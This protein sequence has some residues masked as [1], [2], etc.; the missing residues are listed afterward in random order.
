MK[1]LKFRFILSLS[2]FIVASLSLVAVI[3][4]IGVYN[5]GK[6]FAQQRGIPVVNYVD[7]IIDGDEF[8][9]FVS[10]PTEVDPYYDDT[11]LTLLYLNRSV[12]ASYLYTMTKGINEEGEE[13]YFYIIDGSCPREEDGFSPLMEEEDISDWGPAIL[14]TFEDGEIHCSNPINQKNWGWVVSTYKGIKDSSGK[15]V[16]IIA[17]DFD[18]TFVMSIVKQQVIVIVILSI[19]SLVC[20]FVIIIML[21]RNIFGSMKR[22]EDAM[23]GIASGAADL[24]ARI[25]VKGDN[26]LSRLANNCNAVIAKIDELV[27]ELKDETIILSEEGNDLY[28][29]MQKH[30]VNIKNSASNIQEIDRQVADQKDQIEQVNTG[31]VNV[32]HE[33]VNLDQCVIQQ[34]NAV[35][36]STSAIEEIS[37]NINSVNSSIQ[38]ILDE[39]RTLV[40]SSSE[41]SKLQYE[42]KN[43]IQSIV[44]Q[45]ENL[46]MANQAISDIAEQT[47][48][49]AMNAAIEAAHAGDAGKGFA[50]VA[51]EI[52]SLAETS[53]DQSSAIGEVLN[54]VIASINQIV[55]S[56]SKSAES[57][58]AVGRKISELSNLMTEVRSG[59]E[60]E[61]QGVGHILSTM[62]ML[63]ST[64][65][66]IKN[67]SG[68]MKNESKIL[69]DK[70]SNLKLISD[71]TRAKSDS[72][73]KDVGEMQEAAELAMDSSVKSKESADTVVELLKGYK[74]SE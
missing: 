22:V 4:S 38:I 16:G 56:S 40:D 31:I 24:S 51:D 43:Q 21:T 47:N 49:L 9:E 2:L 71:I 37:S 25:P 55:E 67:A 45:S 3:S 30:L 28:E 11:R 23:K 50:V 65:E 27:K 20:G 13:A 74:V 5:V 18:I 48:L 7:E 42:V 62:Q 12:G 46:T 1:S 8:A 14:Q 73:S 68:T 44:E 66:D 32:E 17:C 15:V 39:Y 34:V 33:I 41:G 52:R 10:D 36:N 63:D 19:V 72:V 58:D 61:S 69:F 26:E 29:S 53:A 64:T 60:E 70:I 59:M 57:F 6:Q 54:Q 35:Q